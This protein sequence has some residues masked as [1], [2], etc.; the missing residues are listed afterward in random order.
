MSEAW[1]HTRAERPELR[2]PAGGPARILARAKETGGAITVVENVVGPGQGPPKHLHEAEDELFYVMSGH[3]HVHAGDDV[4][5]APPGSLVFIPRQMPHVFQNTAAEPASL[6]V[7][8]TPAGMEGFFEGVAAL[9]AGV[10]LADAAHELGK[11]VGMQVLGPP[12]PPPPD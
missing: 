9:D 10:A 4:L 12:L 11:S 3:L 1:V 7:L 2:G 6:L 5:E 8:F